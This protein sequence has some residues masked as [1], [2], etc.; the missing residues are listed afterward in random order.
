MNS[1]AVQ[2][3]GVGSAQINHFLLPAGAV[4]V[5]LGWRDTR[6]K[7]GIQYFDAHIIRSLDHVKACI[8][9]P[10]TVCLAMRF[11]DA[12]DHVL[13]HVLVHVLDPV[14]DHALD[15]AHDHVR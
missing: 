3:S 8:A 15:E 1:A 9:M 11:G 5:C 12:C 7:R 13:G 4:A 14:L 6:A 10:W 2:A